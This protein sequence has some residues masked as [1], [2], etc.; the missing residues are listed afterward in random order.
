MMFG[1][2][3]LEL[4]TCPAPLASYDV[5]PSR[6]DGPRPTWGSA[7]QQVFFQLPACSI[8]MCVG[9]TDVLQIIMMMDK[10]NWTRRYIYA[11][12]LQGELCVREKS[13]VYF[14]R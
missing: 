5:S 8:V 7:L 11:V 14:Q 10:T 1:V 4:S 13:L 9:A 2:R 12:R 6:K 3:K